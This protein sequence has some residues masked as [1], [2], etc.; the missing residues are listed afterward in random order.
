MT[1]KFQLKVLIVGFQAEELDLVHLVLSGY[2]LEHLP[3]GATLEEVKEYDLV[4]ASHE[5]SQYLKNSKHKPTVII[6][7]EKP[8]SIQHFLARPLDPEKLLRMVRGLIGF[9]KKPQIQS[10]KMGAIVKSKTTPTFGKG[11]VIKE[12]SESEVMVRFPLAKDL[13]Q[14]KPLKCHISNLLLIGYV[15]KDKN[16]VE[17]HG[18]NGVIDSMSATK[19]GKT[20]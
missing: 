3:V 7:D 14:G 19:K 16:I 17:I 2:E 12:F 1:Q 9:A 4:I 10:I 5:A 20:L 13:T 18:K 6:A 15:D 11:V 8:G